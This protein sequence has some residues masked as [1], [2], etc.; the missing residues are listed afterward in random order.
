LLA[1]ERARGFEASEIFG[2][3]RVVEVAGVGLDGGDDGGGRNEARD[4]VDVAVRVVAS[5]AAVEPEN[6]IDAEKIVE[7]L[8]ELGAADAGVALLHFAQQTLLGGEQDALAVGVDGT[9]FEDE[10]LRAVLVLD[11]RFPR[12]DAD[13]S[14][15]RAGNWSSSWLLEYLAQPLKSQS[16]RP[17]WPSLLRMKMGPVSRVNCGWWA[18]DGS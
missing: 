15:T 3:R 8:F 18:S 17:T 11:G 16:V 12:G 13:S 4:V 7:G 9:A 14:V 2:E 10:A 5:D 6:L 1:V